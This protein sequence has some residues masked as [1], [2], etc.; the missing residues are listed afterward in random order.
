MKYTQSPGNSIEDF[1]DGAILI[2]IDGG[3][4]IEF[5]ESAKF[6]WEHLPGGA[7]KDELIATLYENYSDLDNAQ[8]ERDVAVFLEESLACGAV[9]ALE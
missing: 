3:R 8:A 2:D 5:N 9:M 6:L 7:T 1:Q 4:V